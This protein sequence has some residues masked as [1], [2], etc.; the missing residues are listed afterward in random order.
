MVFNDTTIFQL[1][2]GQEKSNKFKMIQNSRMYNTN[3][4]TISG[5][6]PGFVNVNPSTP[7]V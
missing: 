4:H 1:Y 5:I 3:P 6:G 2:R 7:V